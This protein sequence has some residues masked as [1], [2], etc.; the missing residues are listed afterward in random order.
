M[1]LMDCISKSYN[2][3]AWDIRTG[4]ETDSEGNDVY[5]TIHILKYMTTITE[6]EKKR[7]ES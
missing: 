4:R 6:E 3:Y 7:R 5:L 2:V 1:N